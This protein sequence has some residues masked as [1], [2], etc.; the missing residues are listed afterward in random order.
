MR[1]PMSRLRIILE[2]YDYP[3]VPRGRASDSHRRGDDCSRRDRDQHGVPGECLMENAGRHVALAV[4]DIGPSPG[5]VVLQCGA[6]NNGGDGF[7]AARHL[8]GWGYHP[9]IWLA[10]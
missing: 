5:R 10:A 4:V 7:V 3:G 8:K 6:G 1:L 9:E 2:V